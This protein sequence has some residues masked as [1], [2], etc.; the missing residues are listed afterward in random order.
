MKT[1]RQIRKSAARA[2]T[3]AKRRRYDPDVFGGRAPNPKRY[4]SRA[5]RRMTRAQGG[6][7]PPVPLGGSFTMGSVVEAM[8][9]LD[10]TTRIG[11]A[12]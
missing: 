12:R 1:A 2:A 10:G 9:G 4:R 5:S 11:F 8:T 3:I 7:Q 6:K